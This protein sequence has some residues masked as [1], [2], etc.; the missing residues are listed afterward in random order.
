M[1]ISTLNKIKAFG[2]ELFDSVL[3]AEQPKI[4]YD[5]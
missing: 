2:S 4:Y 5:P 3:G 1:G